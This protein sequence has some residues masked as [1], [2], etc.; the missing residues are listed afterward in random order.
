[1]DSKSTVTAREEAKKI[2]ETNNNVIVFG[3]YA[4]LGTGWSVNNIWNIIFAAPL[5]SKIAVLQ[6]IGRG[7]RL[8][9]GQKKI[10]QIW[11]IVDQFEYKNILY[12]HYLEREKYYHENKFTCKVINFQKEP[13]LQPIDLI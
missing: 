10:C 3:T 5:K 9:P 2:L 7:L 12:K 6:S 13:Q 11:D 8:I 4:L 1:L